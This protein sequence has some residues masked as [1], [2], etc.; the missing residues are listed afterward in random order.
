MLLF[1]AALIAGLILLIISSDKFIEH[2]ALVAE[3]LNVNPMVIGV[4]LVAFGTSAPEMVVSTMAALDN[5]PEIAIGNVLGS[6]IANVA[7][8]F[9]VT[10]LFSAIPISKGLITKEVPL[11]IGITLLTGWLLHDSYLSFY[12]GVILLIAFAFILFTLLRGS[13]NLESQLKEELPEND[14]DSVAKSLIIS[15]IGLV[16]LI[17]SSKLLIWGAVGIAKG[18]GVSELVIGLTIVAVGTSLPELAASISSV[19][20]GLH[21]IAIGNIIG[22]NIF[23]LATVLPIPGLISPGAIDPN[24]SGRDYYWVLGLTLALSILIF[25]FGKSKKA[26]IPRWI[27][28]P[29]IGSYIAYLLLI[30]FGSTV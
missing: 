16:V 11:V 21:S 20:K 26:T 17:G 3:K 24:A 5:A 12:D 2:A 27:G 23:N 25:V 29:L 6:N 8:V 7:L 9:G 15:L 30:S 4:T 19:R 13:K 1:S 10:L 22:S 14:G 28:I 18:L